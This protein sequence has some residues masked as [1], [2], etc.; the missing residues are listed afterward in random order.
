[1]IGYVS[2]E[3]AEGGPLAV[4][5][6]GDVIRYDIPERRLDVDVPDEELRR[7]FDRWAPPHRPV[8]GYL[9]RY[10]NAVTGST[11]GARLA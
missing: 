9:R 4:V 7:R 3:A 5:E 6:D 1:M 2:P 11:S 8:T 10:A